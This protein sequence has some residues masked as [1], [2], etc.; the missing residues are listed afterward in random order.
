MSR[1]RIDLAGDVHDVG[2]LEAA[3]DMRDRVG[4]AD[5]R[6]ELVAE[7]LALRRAR[8]EARDVDELDDAGMIFCGLTM[9]ASASRRG[10]GTGTTPTFGSIVQNG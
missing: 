6:E 5:V 3:H 9:S 7:A 10:S 4:L 2:V 8:D 1:D